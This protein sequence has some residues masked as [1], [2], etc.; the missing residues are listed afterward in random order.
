MMQFWDDQVVPQ[1]EWWCQGNTLCTDMQALDL[2]AYDAILGYNRLKKHSPMTC[3]WEHQTV[4]FMEQDK[5]ITLQG[6][7]PAP[8]SLSAVQA[9]SFVKWHKGNDVWALAM[10]DFEDHSS[11][12][13]SPELQSLL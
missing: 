2:G 9:D 10:V 3:D 13:F 8:L 11:S 12:S 4:T 5:L 6:V 7:P 1:M